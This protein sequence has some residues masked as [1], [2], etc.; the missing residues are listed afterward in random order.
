MKRFI[1]WALWL[2]FALAVVATF[3]YLWSK[4]QDPE[5][6]YDII[7][8]T[9]GDSIS[10]NL[11]LA[12]SIKPR[13]EV[14]IKP[15]I[16]GIIS[17]LLVEP[18]DEVSVGD[19]IA[20][21]RVIPDMQQI[22]SGES[23]VEQARINVDRLRSIHKR[24]E[25]LHTKGLLATEEYERSRAEL[26]NAELQHRSAVEA[27]QITK[28]GVSN[29]Y[30]K[31]SSTLIRATIAG[32]VLSIPVK[33]GSSVIQANTLNEGTTVATI[34]KMTDLIF[35]GKADETEVGKLRVGLPMKLTI[36]AMPDLK[37]SATVE[38]IS[39]QGVDVS[40]STRFEVRGKLEGL[41][42]EVIRQLRA[43][44]S[45]NAD[46]LI[47]RVTKVMSLPEACITY[48]GDSTF[49]QFVKTEE[50]L[51]TEERHI[52]TGLSD[53]NRVE[54]KSGLKKGDKVRGNE[55]WNSK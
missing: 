1:K 15:Q 47:E 4:G 40:G 14:A 31:E 42:P 45:A 54:I 49:V 52:R 5:K 53:G 17:E 10:K 23:N 50:P 12:G 27:L 29:R 38:Y 25:E 39:P 41:S 48:R 55:V 6:R 28:S 16:A 19:V 18:G 20:K 22:N 21:L 8:V 32:K 30:S 35:E 3:V 46:I 7:T 2:I 26:A 37:L 24:N 9:M 44:F 51:E 43:G 34:A 13:D 33:V 36:G 11:I